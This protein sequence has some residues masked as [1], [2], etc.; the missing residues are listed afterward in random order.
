MTPGRVTL[1][2]ARRE[3][4]ATLEAAAVVGIGPIVPVSLRVAGNAHARRL[5]LEVELMLYGDP[6]A[7]EA[8][9]HGAAWRLKGRLV[10]AGWAA[11]CA[12]PP[13]G[14]PD[15]TL[16]VA[17]AT[18]SD[19]A[20]AELDYTF[21]LTQPPVA[22][23]GDG[24]WQQYLPPGV[25]AAS[26]ARRRD[27][28]RRPLA[29]R[30]AHALSAWLED[31]VPLASLQ[32]AREYACYGPLGHFGPVEAWVLERSGQTDL[33][34]D[35]TPLGCADDRPET[36]G[37][38]AT[39]L[40]LYGERFGTWLL[41]RQHVQH[42]K[43]PHKAAPAPRQ[44]TAEVLI[45]PTAEAL[46]AQC[47]LTPAEKRLFRQAGILPHATLWPAREAWHSEGPA[48]DTPGVDTHALA[49]GTALDLSRIPDRPRKHLHAIAELAEQGRLDAGDT[50]LLLRT[51]RQLGKARAQ[52]RPAT[53]ARA[54]AVTRR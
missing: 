19:S 9:R 14:E 46:M 16:E 18:P 39:L 25:P 30:L 20:D 51:A 47:D 7:Q 32:S 27:A 31:P 43:P 48:C 2:P 10:S 3:D 1:T 38:P 24:G 44:V 11:Q 34:V 40:S 49:P 42:L 33:A 45:A 54:R 52:G 21:T 4:L 53:R 41:H 12:M 29:E 35:A 26:G 37:E 23:K 13:V 50:E 6:P 22:I 17:A 36:G 28:P 15:D 5:L 8:G